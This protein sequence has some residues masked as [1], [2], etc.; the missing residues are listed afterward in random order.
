LLLL[1]VAVLWLPSFKLTKEEE[2]IER[3]EKKEGRIKLDR[4]K[5]E[6]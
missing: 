1:L 5:V 4:E 3:G 2:K 6:E